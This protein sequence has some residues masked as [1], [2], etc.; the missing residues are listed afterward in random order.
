MGWNP[1]K[2]LKQAV[3]SVA[4][5][6]GGVVKSVAG[7]VGGAV[8]GAIG[9]AIPGV[10]TAIGASIGSSIGNAFQPKS[11]KDKG[12]QQARSFSE[13]LAQAYSAKA[14]EGY[15]VLYINKLK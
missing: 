1:F 15:Q 7:T 6:V 9:S 11:K 4:K 13:G 8:G 2:G 12:N 5:A 3:G 14:S 10:G